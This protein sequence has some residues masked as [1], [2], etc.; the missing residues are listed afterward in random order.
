MRLFRSFISIFYVFAVFESAG[1]SKIEWHNVDSLYEPLP[2]NIKVYYSDSKLDSAPFKAYYII[3]DIKDKSLSFT[4]DTTLKRRFTPTQFYN[5]N[6]NPV[7]V[8]NGT[9][10]SFETNQNLNVVIKEGKAVS[11]NRKT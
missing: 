10:F 6:N 3:A 1:Q 11:V 2:K 4:T 7:V 8:V 5:R 9:F